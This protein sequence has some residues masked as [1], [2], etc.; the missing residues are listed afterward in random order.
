MSII[1]I[2]VNT[3]GLVGETVQPRRCTMTT[4]DN[5]AAIT[6]A[7][8]LNNQNIFGNTILPT[9]I[10]EV[11][12][13]FNPTTNIGTF[14][15]FQ[16]QYSVTTGFTMVL[17]T[18]AGADG[19]TTID[20]DTGSAIPVAGVVTMSGGSS[21]LTTAASGST[22]DIT[23]TLAIAHGGTSKTAVTTAPAATSW[24]GWDANKN[25]S[26]NNFLEG[27]TTTATSAGT[28]TLTVASTEQ[29]FFTGSTTQTVVLPVTSTLVLGQSFL[30]VNNSSGTVTVESSGANVIQAMAA[31]TSAVFTVIST[32]GTTAASWSKAYNSGGGGGVTAVQVQDTAFNLGVDSGAADHY[33][34]TLSPAPG[35]YID[36]LQV[37]F[38]ANN[39]NVTNT[40]DVNVNGL[41]VTPIVSLNN[42]NIAV[43][44]INSQ[45][46]D[47]HLVYDAN[48]S[49]FVLQ[50]PGS[51]AG[52][53]Y[54]VE[55]RY[56]FISDDSGSTTAYSGTSNYYPT[57]NPGILS[58][59]ILIYLFVNNTNTGA[60]TFNY[61]SNGAQ[62]IIKTDGTPLV[63]GEMLANGI[64]Q[65]LF[66]LNSGNKWQLLNPFVMQASSIYGTATNNNAAAGYIGEFVTSDIPS[67]SAVS[68]V[69]TTS[70]TITSI[71]LTAGDW[72]VF[73]SVWFT[74]G[75]T[76]TVSLLKGGVNTSTNTLP[77]N[78]LQCVPFIAQTA[79]TAFNVNDVGSAIPT[80]RLSLASTTTV[81]LVGQA[82]FGVST[83]AGY[84][85]LSA[86]RVR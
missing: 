80:T 29:Q 2:N 84:G 27:Y 17:W 38:A 44:D 7:G 62:A 63:G 52:N 34:V 74:G 61:N 32:S 66:D 26:A 45:L 16:I 48:Q 28:T 31:N 82:T 51:G 60:S 15:I 13:S 43:R 30:V 65:L 14:G 18:N 75:A 57:L 79:V 33:V 72:D 3:T 77:A 83:C 68:L 1:S 19:V 42:E 78:E 53:I 25:M 55:N 59:P 11:I 58:T 69:S 54:Q 46:P 85:L 76:S 49:A 86:R 36:G 24:A 10:F 22:V 6:T 56:N 41:G 12:Y 40:P 23:G 37:W 9:D 47:V 39:P 81:Y 67:G 8:Y 35:A 73:G 71:S 70:K 4:T 64:Y 21:G 20:G 5:L 50:N